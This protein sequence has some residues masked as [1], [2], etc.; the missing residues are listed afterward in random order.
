MK[1]FAKIRHEGFRR[2]FVLF[3]IS[4]AIFWATKIYFIVSDRYVN[5]YDAYRKSGYKWESPPT[6]FDQGD[7]WQ[8]PL[9]YIIAV[10]TIFVFYWVAL[11][12]QW[13]IQGFKKPPPDQPP[14]SHE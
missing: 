8:L 13:A 4:Y 14:K 7:I 2:V 5:W 1:L 6:Y 10:S 3:F 11:A 9:M 12:I